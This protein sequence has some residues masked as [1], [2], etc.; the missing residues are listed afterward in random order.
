[1][2]E[3]KTHAQTELL[4][5][6]NRTY[7]QLDSRAQRAEDRLEDEKEK[8][9]DETR[10]KKRAKPSF[11]AKDSQIPGYPPPPPPPPGASPMEV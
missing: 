5:H 4:T 9:A 3:S 6:G 1:M 7:A 2:N 11:V 10:P 8:L